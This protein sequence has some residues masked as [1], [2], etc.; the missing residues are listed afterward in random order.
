MSIRSATFECEVITP[1]FL[2][3]AEQRR[4]EGVEF[5]IP[6]LRGALRWW[7]RALAGG[8]IGGNIEKLAE[9]ESNLL[10]GSGERAGQSRILF[11]TSTLIEK[12]AVN[13]FSPLP[14]RDGS[15]FFFSGIKP[16]TIIQF[17]LTSNPHY[18]E[19]AYFDA[20]LDVLRVTWLLGGIGRRS[21]RGFGAFQPVNESFSTLKHLEKFI[22]EAIVQARKRL[23][24]VSGYSHSGT[25]EQAE[26]PTISRETCS[27]SI[28]KE[29]DSWE[30]LVKDVMKNI[31]EGTKSG[32]ISKKIIGSAN[33]R[34]GSS[35]II[36]AKNL[37]NR[38]I[39]P[40]F[41]LFL[42]RTVSGTITEEEWEKAREFIKESF[43]TEGI[44]FH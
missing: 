42:T 23:G 17:T 30:N 2:A 7:F 26:F 12:S 33:P 9:L 35:L 41:T 16:G 43:R 29:Y 24:D 5:R 13:N 4:A 10:G 14:H 32:K 39:V 11:R 44:S 20:T 19:E 3:G 40:V 8:L 15:R 21:R 38:K 22:S 31:H 6:S 36:T 28:G 37:L 27:I 34:Q 1:M 25:A 18:K